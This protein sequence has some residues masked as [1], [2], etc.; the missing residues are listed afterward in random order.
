MDDNTSVIDSGSDDDYNDE[1]AIFDED[2]QD[3]DMDRFIIEEEVEM[4]TSSS[5][6]LLNQFMENNE[7]TPKNEVTWRQNITYIAPSIDWYERPVE[8]VYDLPGPTALFSKYVPDDILSL[9]VEMT[10]LYAVQ[11]NIARF[12][13]TNLLE[14]K[15]LIGMHILMGNL[16]YPRTDMYWDSHM[17]IPIIRENMRIHR[18]YKLRQ[19][20]H[21]VDVTN[22]GDTTDRLWKVR[23]LF[24]Q[25]RKVC[26]SLPLEVDLCIDEQ[27]VPFKGQINIKQYI[28][29]KPNKWGIKI[30]I[31]AGKS[32]T[33][34]DFII[35]Q[36]ITTELNDLYKSLGVTSATVMQL[37]DRIIEPNHR[38]YF[39]NYFNSYK[40]LQ[41]LHNKNIF[42]IGTARKCRFFNPPLLSEKEMKKKG[43]GSY[44]CIVSGDGQVIM[45]TWYD[46]K[47][48]VVAS[49]YMGSGNTDSCQRWDRKEKTRITV[50][51][52][53]CIS[54]YNKSMGGVDKLDFL[55]SLY[56]S[57]IRSKKWTLR[58]ITHAIDLS[59][60]NS[61]LEYKERA[62]ALHIPKKRVLDL[63]NFRQCVAEDLIYPHISRKRGRP[64]MSEVP[65]PGPSST[66]EVQPIPQMRWDGEQHYPQWDDKDSETRC[67]MQDC[68]SKTHIFCMKCKV[69]LCLMRKRNCF[70]EYHK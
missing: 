37:A 61:W 41:Y 22:K 65:S 20:I 11:K 23:P 46:N 5:S 34:Y 66:F 33:I 31:L 29:S 2:A 69:H 70:Y 47:Q 6:D 3:I 68:K 43:R 64:S 39:D 59:L 21:L 24:D 4:I 10:N 42:A 30:Y 52:P 58:M 14:I 26:H 12:P 53:E 48:V 44:D 55:A 56:R 63:L 38:L 32:G 9:F 27:I 1:Q 62:N 67:K 25:I 16:N 54:L 51:R 45:T 36:G 60:I 57:H 13:A 50:P 28:K 15:K 8:E 40:L 35:Y 19:A 18:F 7:F 17:G 49:N